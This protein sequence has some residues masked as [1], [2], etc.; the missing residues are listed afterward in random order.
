MVLRRGPMPAR[1]DKGCEMSPQGTTPL[2]LSAVATL[3]GPGSRT[4][5][6]AWSPDGEYLA[7]IFADGSIRIWPQ[8]G[9]DVWRTLWAP[10]GAIEHVAWSPDSRRLAA[11]GRGPGLLLGG[12]CESALPFIVLCC[13]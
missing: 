6:S 12:E 13:A 10:A 1:S 7:V 9:G 3:Q 4:V 5:H 11:G 2:G 8:D